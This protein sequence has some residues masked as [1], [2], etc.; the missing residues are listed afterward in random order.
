MVSRG[1]RRVFRAAKKFSAEFRAALSLLKQVQ[2]EKESRAYVWVQRPLCYGPPAAS[3]KNIYELGI[4]QTN[5][6]P[7]YYAK[8]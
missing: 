7:S 2:R 8:I 6:R 4:H 3:A 5:F 1:G